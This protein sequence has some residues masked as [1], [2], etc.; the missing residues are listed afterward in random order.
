MSK[1]ITENKLTRNKAAK[2]VAKYEAVLTQANINFKTCGSW[3][4][5]KAEIG[6]LDF[7]IT[8]KL[9]D[10]LLIVVSKVLPCEVNRSGSSLL[11]LRV[12]VFGK[13]IQVEFITVPKISFGSACLHA[14][15]NA[16]FNISLRTYCK[17]KGFD[18]L[19]Q[20]GLFQNKIN[21]A[22]KSEEDVFAQLG[23]NIIPPE[24][25]SDFWKI[26]KSYKKGSI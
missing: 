15:G 5:G 11:S 17:Q 10:D 22:S 4:R 6:D 21:V 13:K 26:Y 7:V 8:D 9:I 23:L 19:N 12:D 25:R 20:Y 18:K 2:I 3:R 14:T 16:E 24:N 1:T